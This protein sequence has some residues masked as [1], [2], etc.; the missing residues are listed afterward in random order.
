[1]AQ[2]NQLG[3]YRRE[4]YNNSRSRRLT[5]NWIGIAAVIIIATALSVSAIQNPGQSNGSQSGARNAGVKPKRTTERRGK[6]SASKLSIS[7]VSG[8]AESSIV[9]G[10][11]PILATADFDLVGLAV[12]AGPSSLTVPKNTPTSIQTS[13]RVPDGTDPATIIG[14]LNPNYR[15]RGELTGPSLTAPLTLEAPIGQ[16]LNIPPLTNAGDHQVRNL[17]VVDTGLPDQPVVTTVTPDSCGIVVIERL[18]ISQVEVHELTYD[19]IIQAGIN[20]TDDS[21]RA[22]NFVLGIGTTSSPQTITIPVAFPGVGVKSLPPV[23]GTPSVS[24]PDFGADVPSVIPVMLTM[25][26]TGDGKA[27]GQP[28]MGGDGQPVRI[29]RVIIFPARVGF[30]HKFFEAIVIVGNGAPGGTPLVL[31]SLHASAHLP[32]NGTPADLSDDPLRIATTQTGGR[33]SELDLHGLGPDGKYGT[34]DD[35]VSFGPGQS[36]QASFLLEGLKEGL[37]PIDFDLEAMLEGLPGGPIKVRGEVSGAVLVRDASFAVTFTH[38]GVVRAGNEYDLGMTIYN[39]GQTDIHGAF[40]ELARNS[41]SGAELIGQDAGE[42]Q[43]DTTIKRGESATVKWRLRSNTT[44]EV[45]ASYVKVGD[46]ISAGLALVTGV[47]DRNIPLSPD[48]LILPDPVKQLPSNVVEAARAL[49]GQAWSIANAPPGSLPAGMKPVTK[50]TVVNRAVELG[51]A[52]MRVDFGEQVGVSLD[53][54]LR[55][56]LGELQTVPDPGF[57]DTQRNT[58]SGYE[59]F[60]SLGDE[61]YKRLNAGASSVSPLDLHQEFANTELPRS[62]FISALVTHANGQPIAGARFVDAKGNRVGFGAS[63]DERDGALAQGS[64]IRLAHTDIISGASSSVGEML[65]VSNPTIDNWTLEL[66]GWQTGSV[67]ISL[68]APA[69]SQAYS[70]FVWNGVQITQGGKYR[71]RFKPL[72]VTTSPVLEEFKNGSWQLAAVTAAVTPLNQPSP[73]VVG[74]IQVTPEVVGGG[75]KYGRLIGILFSKPMLQDQAQTLSRYKIGGGVLKGLSPAQ[76]VGDPISVTGAKIDYG[77]RF[78]F[79]SLNS[80]IGP[81][82]DRDLTI[83]SLQDSHRL[84]LSPSPVTRTITPRVSPDG[85]PPGAYL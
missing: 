77:N 51:I 64:S 40:A 28:P 82:I 23:V 84:S 62:T 42:R 48:S 45:T 66:N 71:I 72:S 73:R 39:S 21:Y 37:H 8:V 74:V 1:M 75:D 46:G 35:T 14:E 6:R 41:I 83:T 4:H 11:S 16:A 60:D 57:A 18:L 79:R 38:P 49:L 43:F 53:T 63:V 78:V 55:D 26:D 10:T 56:W 36:G 69:T 81:Y 70:Q 61:F 7:S 33:V 47:G 68:L 31:H 80:T 5:R 29:P 19:Q 24:G 59:W 65:A 13:V 76:Q 44:G 27:S 17:R 50:Q 85:V 30:L 15:V 20:I 9:D 2:N 3:G 58:R 54:I 32:N 67:D 52:G 34:G 22:F 12:T 25:P